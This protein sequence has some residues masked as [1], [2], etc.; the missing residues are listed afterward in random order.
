MSR[1]GCH[2]Q[3]RLR[4]SFRAWPHGVTDSWDS[5]SLSPRLLGGPTALDNL[6]ALCFECSGGK[7]NKDGA[8][9]SEV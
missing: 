2:L 8:E 6:Q 7:N 5:A 3:S 4:R 9:F 1:A